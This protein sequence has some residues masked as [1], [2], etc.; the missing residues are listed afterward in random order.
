MRLAK[1]TLWT[2]LVLVL[3]AGIDFFLRPVSYFNASM[4]LR[5]AFTGVENRTVQVAGHRI[6]Y[7]AEGPSN[8]PAVVLVHGLGGRAED[9]LNLAPYLA[10]AGFRVYMPDLVGYGRSDR[11]ADFPY[12][13]HDE[14]AIV[15]GFFDALHLKQVELG[16]WSMGGWIVE[17]VAAGHPE[18][19]SRLILFDAAGLY[20]APSWNTGLFTPANAAE[21][22]QLEA[23]LM[24][25]PPRTPSFVARDILRLARTDGWVVRR[26]LSTMWTGQDATDP[27][28]PTLKMPVLIEWGA[29]DRITPPDQ[30]EKMHQLIPQ[31]RLDM[32]PGCGHLAPRQ[33]TAQ[34][35][36]KV[37]TFAQQ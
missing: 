13:V 8:G 26:A 28:L 31:S 2:L 24:P 23:L 16:G 9:W 11:P 12:T 21:L 34:I 35:G 33:C 37:V 1:R 4:Y 7:L 20:A 25:N 3:I 30:A 15:V 29:L 6:H 10:K 5:E 19:V 36:P 18:R 17:L 22:D 27:L 14:A 32:I